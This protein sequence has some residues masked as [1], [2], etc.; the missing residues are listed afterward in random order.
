MNN[1]KTH[2]LYMPCLLLNAQFLADRDDQHIEKNSMSY[3][4]SDTSNIKE[5]KQQIKMIKWVTHTQTQHHQHAPTMK[6][7][8]SRTVRSLPLHHVLC[9]WP[10]ENFS[11]RISLIREVRNAKTKG[12]SERRPNS[13]SRV[14]KRSQVPPVASQ[15]LQ[16]T[17]WAT[18]C[19]LSSGYW[20]PR[21]RSWLHSKQTVPGHEL[22]QS[23]QVNRL[24]PDMSCHN[25][26]R[27]PQRNGNKCT[28]EL[29]INCA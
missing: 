8:R 4:P 7:K 15:G 11:Q 25:L 16:A 2:K 3:L 29:K 9:P 22:P 24:C 13:S 21:W 20:S 26:N 5:I 1:N 6:M 19:E 18:S 27:W 12:N 17:F 10:V 14:I 23:Q 28:P